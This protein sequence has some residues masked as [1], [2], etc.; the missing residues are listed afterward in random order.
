VRARDENEGDV[1]AIDE[2]LAKLEEAV[3]TMAWPGL[4]R[5]DYDSSL[6]RVY[7][8]GVRD[9]VTALI[10]A[11]LAAWGERERDMPA[12]P[13]CGH[14]HEGICASVNE[15]RARDG[16]PPLSE[17]AKPAEGEKR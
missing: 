11:K 12:C 2:A 15:L 1:T 3:M 16:V 4:N 17:P 7:V 10:D 14:W 13:A 8:K 6:A 9:A 5:A